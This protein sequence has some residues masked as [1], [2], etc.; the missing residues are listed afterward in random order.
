ME[1]VVH[2]VFEALVVFLMVLLVLFRFDGVDS[3]LIGEVAL[4][5][6]VTGVENDVLTRLGGHVFR[7]DDDGLKK[8]GGDLSLAKGR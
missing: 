4:D 8:K 2:E 3:G 6:D 7:D 5:G 1:L